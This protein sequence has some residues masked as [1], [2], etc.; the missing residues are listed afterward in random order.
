MVFLV[1]AVV[2]SQLVGRM[3]VSLAAAT[4]REREALVRQ[5]E[6]TEGESQKEMDERAAH[7][8]DAQARRE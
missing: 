2:I 6:S 7:K 1:V 5:N 4:S 3:Q 8:P